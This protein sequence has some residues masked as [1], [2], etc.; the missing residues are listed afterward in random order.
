MAWLAFTRSIEDAESHGLEAPL[1][2]WRA[3]RDEIHGVVCQQGFDTGLN[4]FVQCF[5]EKTLDASLLLIPI[6]GF[7]PGTDPRVAGTVEA[8][9]R[10]LMEDGFV[11]RYRT[12]EHDDGL[13]GREGAFLACSF[14]LASAMHLQGREEEA[15]AMFERLLGLCNDVGLL[16]EEYD[17]RARRFTGNFPQAFSHVALVTTALLLGGI[18]A[19]AS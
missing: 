13:P 14:W 11:L 18:R 2:R 19:S 3:V 12:D 1:G 17:P 7:L 5:G 9:E 8:I 4:S 15:R 16:A 10:H 6:A